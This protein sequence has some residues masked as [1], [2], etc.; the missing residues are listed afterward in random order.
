MR[1][2][3]AAST[4]PFRRHSQGGCINWDM[5]D[6]SEIERLRARA[7]RYR[8]LAASASPWERTFA[9]G[10]AKHFERLVEIAETAER[11]SGRNVVFAER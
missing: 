7:M 1:G 11:Q 2:Q 3:K 9:E 8:D 6:T 4:E 10:I 5:S